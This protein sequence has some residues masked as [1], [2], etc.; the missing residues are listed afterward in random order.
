MKHI[1][2]LFICLIAFSASNSGAMGKDPEVAQA[3]DDLQNLNL[4]ARPQLHRIPRL[5]GQAFINA[6]NGKLQELVDRYNAARNDQEN[7]RN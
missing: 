5:Y 4:N 6:H 2:Y 3:Q 1:I 7:R